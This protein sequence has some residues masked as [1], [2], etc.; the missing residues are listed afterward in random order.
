MKICFLFYEGFTAL[1]LIGPYEVLARLPA[2]EIIRV[3][4]KPGAV[5]SGLGLEFMVET[6]LDDCTSADVIVVP[7]ACNATSLSH[8]PEIL[9]WLKHIHETTLWTTSVCTGSLILGAAGILAHKRATSHWAVMDRLKTFSALP[10]PQRIVEEGKII[11]AA[12]VSAGID[13]ALYLT[14]KLYGRDIAETI[15]LGLEYDPKPPFNSGSL[16]KARPE[17]RDALQKTLRAKFEK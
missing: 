3:A 15:Q 11:T 6:A 14:G 17:I 13:M 7:G 1:D 2:V 12:G 5:L 10:L 9:Q 8:E 16:T 4:K